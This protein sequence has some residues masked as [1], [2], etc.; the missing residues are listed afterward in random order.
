VNAFATVHAEFLDGVLM[1]AGL[2][3]PTLVMGM[4]PVGTCRRI[5]YLENLFALTN[6]H[7]RYSQDQLNLQYFFEYYWLDWMLLGSDQRINCYHAQHYNQVNSHFSS[8]KIVSDQQIKTMV[9][10]FLVKK[11]T[12]SLSSQKDD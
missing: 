5:A 12:T 1:N 6:T 3:L 7:L 8:F 11:A 10:P 4:A 2:W 9:D